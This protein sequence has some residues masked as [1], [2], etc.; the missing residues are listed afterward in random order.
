[1]TKVREN[2]KFSLFSLA[3]L[4]LL[5]L[6][7]RAD[8]LYGIPFT[9]MIL[10]IALF[11]CCLVAFSYFSDLALKQYKSQNQQLLK[12]QKNIQDKD[13]QLSTLNKK[14]KSY[15]EEFRLEIENTFRQW[16]F[17]RAEA[18]VASLLLKGLS[19]KEVAE[20]RQANEQTVRSQ[21]SSIYKKSKL[22]NRSQLSSY[23]LDD[24]I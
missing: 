7:L 16:G 24:L 13:T 23:F 17:T 14:V 4:V 1:M 21:C 11:F 12:L 3:L 5:L 18:E 6:D 22:E 2:I 19:T 8:Y 9:H 15:K 10:E 20:L